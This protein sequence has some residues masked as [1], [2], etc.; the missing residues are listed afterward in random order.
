M[1]EDEIRSVLS[2]KAAALVER[3]AAALDDLINPG[4]VYVNA[5]GAVFDKAGY[6][7]AYCVSGRVIFSGQAIETLEV[8]AFDGFA[9]ATMIVNDRFAVN[10]ATVARRFRSLAVFNRAADRWLWAAGQTA[11]VD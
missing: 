9:V 7:D 8:R 6:I 5:T 1:I 10:G 11:A 4:F 2:A 3:S